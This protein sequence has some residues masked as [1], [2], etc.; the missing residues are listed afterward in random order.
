MST[1]QEAAMRQALEALISAQADEHREGPFEY[2]AT[3]IT[4]LREALAQQQAAEP[5]DGALDRTLKERDDAED[6]IDALLDEVLGN[7]RPEWSS[8]YGRSDALN[9]VRE[10]LAQQAAEPVGTLSIKSKGHWTTWDTEWH[11]TLPPGEYTLYLHSAPTQQPVLV[12]DL[13]EILGATVPE[14][15][16]ALAECGGPRRSTNMAVSGEEALA[17]AAQL[18]QAAE[19]VA[20]LANGTRFKMSFFE[21]EDGPGT[22]VTCFEAFE[23]ELDG[24]WVALVAAEDDCHLKLTQ[25]A[26]TQQPAQQAAESLTDEIKWP[27]ARDVGRYGDMSP[28]AHLRIGLDS[29]NDVYVHVWGD[30]GGA[31]VE[32][33]TGGGGGGSS[34]ATRAALIALMCA[35]EADNAARPDKDWWARRNG[36]T[37]SKT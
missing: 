8:A 14:V 11:A 18:K 17:V 36:I 33:C 20:F 28:H 9:D 10:R 1:K 19:P 13:A 23:K 7:K 25:P 32:F 24:R 3:V 21:N 22:H 31:S 5:V 27:K 37:G 6:F 2:R 15:C 12:R 4:A 30:D 29:D 26:P 35:M 16:D 34:P